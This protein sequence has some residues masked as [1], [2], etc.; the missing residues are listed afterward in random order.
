MRRSVP[1]AAVLGGLLV[2]SVAI[3]VGLAVVVSRLWGGIL[4]VLPWLAMLIIVA[5]VYTDVRSTLRDHS[6]RVGQLTR[7]T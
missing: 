3:H 7:R 1:K 5:K 6:P 2:V 4:P